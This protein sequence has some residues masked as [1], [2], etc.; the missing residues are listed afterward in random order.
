L[1][2]NV[3][4]NYLMTSY[5]A[6]SSVYC[7]NVKNNLNIDTPEKVQIDNISGVHKSGKTNNDEIYL[8]ISN[9]VQY[10]PRGFEKFYTNLIGMLF[11][12][13]N[14]KEIH[15]EDLKPFPKLE[16]FQIHSFSFEI[17]EQ[18]LFDFNPNLEV[19]IF[20]SCKIFHIHPT[21]FDNLSKLTSLL[22]SGNPC[23]SK[24]SYGNKSSVIEVINSAKS[25]CV[26]EV[27]TNLDSKLTSIEAASTN[28]NYEK[29]QTFSQNLKNFETEFKSS[30]FVG[31]SPLKERF[32]RLKGLRIDDL[33]TTTVTTVRPNDEQCSAS[34]LQTCLNCCNIDDFHAKIEVN[35]KNLNSSIDDLKVSQADTLS[36]LDH[37]FTDFGTKFSDLDE[38]MTAFEEKMIK[39]DEKL[40]K[41]E[42]SLNEKM[43]KNFAKIMSKLEYL[44]S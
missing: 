40:E 32:G 13:A 2:V 10:F 8:Q 23:I 36:M 12:S 41:L 17:V 39:I 5:Y 11:L 16:Y 38:K 7:C 31:F 26:S 14:L 34:K 19:I 28:L 3:E 24:N 27:Y 43:D 35:H 37:K 9:N 21:V 42:K 25:T 4:C 22:L 1:S 33:T 15:Q 29:F 30:K 20:E 18:G 6:K 44:T